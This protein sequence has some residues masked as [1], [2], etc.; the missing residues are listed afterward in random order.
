MSKKGP[1]TSNLQNRS[2]NKYLLTLSTAFQKS[3]KTTYS[4]WRRYCAT[5]IRCCSVN[6]ASTVPCPGLKPHWVGSRSETHRCQQLKALI[7]K[8]PSRQFSRQAKT[9]ATEIPLYCSRTTRAA[10]LNNFWNRDQLAGAHAHGHHGTWLA[11]NIVYTQQKLRNRA[12]VHYQN[13]RHRQEQ[14][15]QELS[16][17]LMGIR[18]LASWDAPCTAPPQLG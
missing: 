7:L 13:Q 18:G 3:A 6:I 16:S 9:T 11:A 14:Q 17:Q 15:P 1:C 12:E 4:R 2:I 5:L 10:G 8:Q